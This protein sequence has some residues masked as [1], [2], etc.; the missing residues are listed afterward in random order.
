MK[1]IFQKFLE[2]ETHHGD[3]ER[4]DYVRKKALDYVE[5]KSG[6]TDE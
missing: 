1:S 4:Q 2:F 5:S 3:E 6:A